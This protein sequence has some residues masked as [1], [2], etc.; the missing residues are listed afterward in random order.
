MTWLHVVETGVWDGDG[1][2]EGEE[3][4]AAFRAVFLDK[5]LLCTDL[6]VLTFISSFPLCDFGTTFRA[7]YMKVW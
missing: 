7:V 6:S 3:W 1:E 5:Q 4:T 2:G